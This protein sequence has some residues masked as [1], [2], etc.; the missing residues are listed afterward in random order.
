MKKETWKWVLI[1]TL[2]LFLVIF[3]AQNYKIV[4]IRF[5]FWAF[6]TSRAIV[7][8]ATFLIGLIVGWIIGVHNKRII[9]SYIFD[10]KLIY[11]DWNNPPFDKIRHSLSL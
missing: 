10:I 3:T 9:K 1:L 7:I 8:F 11:F 2:M 4:E 5:L 6:S